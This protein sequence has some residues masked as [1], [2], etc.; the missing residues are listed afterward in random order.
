MGDL[1]SLPT[2]IRYLPPR[3]TF[4]L[5]RHSRDA[6]NQALP[7]ISVLRGSKVT[8]NIIVRAEEGEPGNEASVAEYFQFSVVM[9]MHMFASPRVFLSYIVFIS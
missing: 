3:P 7:P 5:Q 6:S 1:R 8:R 9:S 2:P 4:Y